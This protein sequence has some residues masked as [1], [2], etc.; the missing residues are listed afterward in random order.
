MV[1]FRSPRR[2]RKPL[3]GTP[4]ALLTHLGATLD[5]WDP[6][7]VDALAQQHRVI[8]L[9]ALPGAGSSTV[10]RGGGT[11]SHHWTGRSGPPA[12]FDGRSR[13]R[14]CGLIGAPGRRYGEP[15]WRFH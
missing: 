1:C 7:V 14:R 11:S 9:G 12:R 3:G 10:S 6:R 5:E 2:R 4:V 15:S 13:G 8:A